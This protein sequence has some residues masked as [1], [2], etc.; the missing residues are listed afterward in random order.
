MVQPMRVTFL[1]PCYMWTPSGGFKVIYEH[2]NRLVERGHEV[3]VV[4]PRRLKFPPPETMTVRKL[5]RRTRIRLTE[6]LSKPVIYWHSI[7]PRVRLLYV[8]SSDP[9]HIPNADVLF[10]TAWHTVRSVLECPSSRG[11]RCYFIQHYETWMGPQNLV[12]NTWRAPLHKA[13]VSRWLL[14]VGARL[15]ST[16]LAYIPNGIDRH[17]YQLT[18]PI[19]GR[20]LKVVMMYSAVE[21]KGCPDGVK[22]LEIAKNKFPKLQA[23]LFGTCRRPSWIPEWITY[24]QDPSQE[25]IVSELYNKAS[26]VLSP[27][28]SEGFALPPAEGAVCGC[29]IVATD[30]G[31]VRD[32]VEHGT[33]GLLSP[34][35]NPEALAQNLCLLL[36]NDDLRIRLAKAANTQ[37]TRFTWEH[38][39]DLLEKFIQNLAPTSRPNN[40][41]FQTTEV[42]RAGEGRPS[43]ATREF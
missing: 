39:T 12:D 20:T 37:M 34:P 32:F 42:G 11:E 15:G 35:Q 4:H 23:S 43:S 1:M 29:A 41:L 30:S 38:S 36:G 21:F 25:Y 9:G 24:E 33:T 40:T 27:S 18:Q 26:I 16:D 13:V 14:E 17:R 10:A 28:W 22:A 3:N 5:A 7:D 2:A 19:E 6:V 31:G 8:P